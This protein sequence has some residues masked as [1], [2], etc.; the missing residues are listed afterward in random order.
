MER[1]SKNILQITRINSSFQV[2]FCSSILVSS[3]QIL[4]IVKY[5][6]F[7]THSPDIRTSFYSEWP[8]V[9]LSAISDLFPSLSF[10]LH[11][12][13][14][15]FRVSNVFAWMKWHT[16]FFVIGARSSAIVERLEQAYSKL[17]L[18]ERESSRKIRSVISG[19]RFSREELKRKIQTEGGKENFENYSRPTTSQ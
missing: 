15:R 11:H 16:L 5:L 13:F 9:G 1:H 7:A 14:A 18:E 6:I 12:A 19:R 8:H 17:S 4:V 10:S 3:L 2:C